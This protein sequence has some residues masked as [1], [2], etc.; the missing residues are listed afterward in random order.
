MVNVAN[1][2]CLHEFISTTY[3]RASTTSA[4]TVYGRLTHYLVHSAMGNDDAVL[5]ITCCEPKLKV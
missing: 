5:A 4:P 2:A 3:V 1:F